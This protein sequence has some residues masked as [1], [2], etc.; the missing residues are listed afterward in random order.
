M[1]CRLFDN[2]HCSKPDCN[3]KIGT[4]RTVKKGSVKRTRHPAKASHMLS[5]NPRTWQRVDKLM[6][7]GRQERAVYIGRSQSALGRDKPTNLNV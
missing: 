7:K 3:I 5:I 2:H 6:Y 4:G 1:K